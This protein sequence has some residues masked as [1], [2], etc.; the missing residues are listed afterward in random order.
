[1]PPPCH[2]PKGSVP[3]LRPSAAKTKL[4]RKRTKISTDYWPIGDLL[5]FMIFVFGQGC[6]V[7]L[8]TLVLHTIFP[9]DKSAKNY[10]VFHDWKPFV[11][12]G[13]SSLQKLFTP[14]QVIHHST[15]RIFLKIDPTQIVLRI[16]Y[17]LN[18][19]RLQCFLPSFSPAILSYLHQLPILGFPRQ[20]YPP[21]ELTL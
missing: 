20:K 19:P 18:V 17:C 14:V 7:A 11:N 6:D 13:A 2:R 1:M 8:W 9:L 3:L 21:R 4:C 5:L 12:E 16:N 15:S 10:L